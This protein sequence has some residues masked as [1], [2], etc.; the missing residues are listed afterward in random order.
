MEDDSTSNTEA[1]PIMAD[2]TNVD[3]GDAPKG[4]DDATAKSVPLPEEFQLQVQDL[5][6]NATKPQLDF[7]QSMCYKRSSDLNKAARPTDPNIDDFETAKSE[8]E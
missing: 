2:D 4:A 5:L 1:M 6:G 7:I 8:P 3:T